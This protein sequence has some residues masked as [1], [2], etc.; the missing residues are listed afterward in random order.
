MS[1]QLIQK[2]IEYVTNKKMSEETFLIV[3]DNGFVVGSTSQAV[4][5]FSGLK[6]EAKLFISLALTLQILELVFFPGILAR[7]L[8]SAAALGVDKYIEHR[9]RVCEQLRLAM[10]TFREKMKEFLGDG[11]TTMVFTEDLKNMVHV[12]ESDEDVQLVAKMLKKYTIIT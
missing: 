4:C 8:F 6:T 5:F 2:Y 10:P 1:I 3:N 11:S 7:N 9:Q 12:A